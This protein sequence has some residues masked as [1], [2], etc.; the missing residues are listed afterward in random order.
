[1]TI[2]RSEGVALNNRLEIMLFNATLLPEPV[3]P[4]TRRCGILARSVTTGLPE[5][6]LPRARVS[7]DFAALK[8]SADGPPLARV[9]HPGSADDPALLHVHAGRGATMR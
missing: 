1:M 5:M 2:L 8:V 4:A 3:V 6:S 9:R 7:L